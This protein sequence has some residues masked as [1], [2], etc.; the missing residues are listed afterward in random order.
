MIIY[1][2]KIQSLTRNVESKRSV[3]SKNYFLTEEKKAPRVLTELLNYS[4]YGNNLTGAC[5]ES[6]LNERQ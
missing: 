3:F 2:K 1:N 5:K 4:Q 6:F